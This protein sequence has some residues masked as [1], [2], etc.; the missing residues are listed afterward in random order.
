MIGPVPVPSLR[1]T[2]LPSAPPRLVT[3][4]AATI[5]ALSL[6]VSVSVFAPRLAPLF[7]LFPGADS[8]AE[9]ESPED[10]S[11]RRVRRPVSP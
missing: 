8:H 1:V 2:S 11:P 10:V 4:A 6:P 5:A 9:F 7:F 3:A